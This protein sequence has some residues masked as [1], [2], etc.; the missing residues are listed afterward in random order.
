MRYCDPPYW[1]MKPGAFTAYD[2]V[3][4]T[5]AHQ[6]ALI[7]ALQASTQRCVAW[8]LRGIHPCGPAGPSS[9]LD[10]AQRNRAACH[11]SVRQATPHATPVGFEG[12]RR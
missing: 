6:T 1:P 3:T 10:T 2:G 7:D 12:M 9:L 8:A 11:V 4:V 5:E